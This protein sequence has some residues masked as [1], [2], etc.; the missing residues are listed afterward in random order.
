MMSFIYNRLVAAAMGGITWFGSNTGLVCTLD[1][2]K[3]FS[4]PAAAE[5]FY[6]PCSNPMIDGFQQ[7]T[8]P[9]V[10]RI[11]AEIPPLW[12]RVNQQFLD[13]TIEGMY[14]AAIVAILEGE[15]LQDMLTKAPA[16]YVVV[17][18]LDLVRK[19]ML[20][21][22]DGLSVQP[23]QVYRGAPCEST[24]ILAMYLPHVIIPAE[25]MFS[26]TS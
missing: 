1:G 12:P 18:N 21:I 16:V 5:A 23:S 9:R 4:D 11:S 22:Q 7:A 17:Q 6:M 10:V 20:Y 24:C 14:Q 8:T 25:D 19:S 3:V 15:S 26:S 13:M 2:T